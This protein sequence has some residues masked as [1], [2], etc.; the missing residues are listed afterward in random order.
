[1]VLKM[2]PFRICFTLFE[3]TDI[4]RKLVRANGGVGSLRSAIKTLCTHLLSCELF[5]LIIYIQHIFFF[6]CSSP[7]DERCLKFRIAFRA[8]KITANKN[9]AKKWKIELKMEGNMLFRGTTF[10]HIFP[11]YRR[12]M[13]DKR[14]QKKMLGFC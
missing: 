12:M 4:R 8:G 10:V 3:N 11:I 7:C 1:M 5:T 2:L 9:K 13:N 14:E 6:V